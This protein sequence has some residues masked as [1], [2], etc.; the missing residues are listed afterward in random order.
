MG[1]DATGRDRARI[2]IEAIALALLTAVPLLPYFLYLHAHPVPRFA[3]S[4]DYAGL[5]LATRYVPS[6]RTLLGP[7]SR[8]GFNHPGPLYFYALWPVYALWG[9]TSTGIFA[10]ACAVNTMAAMVTVGAARLATTRAHAIAVTLVV[11]AWLSAF[12][13]AC[14]VPWN[15]LVIVL[16]MIAYLVLAA[17]VANG[18]WRALPFAVLAGAFVVET[19][20]ST[21]PAVVAIAVAT[22]TIVAVRLRRGHADGRRA[23]PS[24]LAGLVVLVLAVAPPVVEQL[25]TNDGNISKLA[26]FFATRTEPMKPLSMALSDWS[27]ATGWLPDRLRTGAIVSELIPEV[28]S[29]VPP[30]MPLAASAVRASLALVLLSTAAFAIA[31]R[32]RDWPSVLLL[33]LGGLT[34]AVAILALRAIVGLDFT[35]LLF[36]TTAA[37][38]VMWMGVLTTVAAALAD[39]FRARHVLLARLGLV[40]A[41]AL[42][43]ALAAR[44]TTLQ[45]AHLAQTRF[46]PGPN[47]TER[48]MYDA[49]RA[50][51]AANGETPVIHAHGAWEMALAFLLEASKDGM[52]ARVVDRER[53]ILGRQWPGVGGV[54]RPLHVYLQTPYAHV[55]LRDCLQKLATVAEIDI[56]TSPTDVEIC[57]APPPP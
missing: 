31:L 16:P 17:L 50:R 22:A 23:K 48:A 47:A 41:L 37:T 42:T 39:G 34:S 28:M 3:V 14:V 9:K 54:A 25:I 10:G 33:G 8:F 43:L 27:F 55:L 52:D 20:L 30:P 26:R 1:S 38:T 29:S 6:G 18:S 2:A 51:L 12:G 35:Y 56:Y 24:A 21:V 5:E 11:I 13:D 53:Y 44:A 7:Y 36:W 4:G 19:H 32:R 46:A 49:V 15:P 40:P 45:R 57:P